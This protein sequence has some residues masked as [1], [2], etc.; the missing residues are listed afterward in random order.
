MVESISC[1]HFELWLGVA[2][3]M[4]CKKNFKHIVSYG[5]LILFL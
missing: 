4:L 1:Y 5:G 2:M 3:R